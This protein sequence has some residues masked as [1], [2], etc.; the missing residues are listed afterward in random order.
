M[1]PKSEIK[2]VTT[3]R[4]FVYP[5]RS[6]TD[7]DFDACRLPD[8]PHEVHGISESRERQARATKIGRPLDRPICPQKVG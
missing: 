3:R 2:N 1:K 8:L 7:P 4:I 6:L 5:W